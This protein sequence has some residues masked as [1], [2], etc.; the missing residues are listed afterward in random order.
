[1]ASSVTVGQVTR[2]VGLIAKS[3]EALAAKKLHALAIRCI[4]SD[5]NRR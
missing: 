1:M 4:E 5:D 3:F 2:T